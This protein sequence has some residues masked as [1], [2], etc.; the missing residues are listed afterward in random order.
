M[1]CKYL[2][3]I[4]GLFAIASV[5]FCQAQESP[6]VLVIIADDLGV[7]F[8]DGFGVDGNNT[9]TPVIDSLRNNGITFL[10]TWATPQCTPT[11]AAIMSGKY[12]VK[13]GV[14]QVPGNL[15]LE[16][17]SIFSNLNENAP[18]D[19]TTAVIGKWHISN[20]VDVTHPFQHG[21]S[22]YEG[23]INGTIDDYYLWPKTENGEI[24]DVDEYVTTHFTNSA[25]DWISQQNQ[26]WLMFLSH[27]APHSPFQVPP[28][29]LYSVGS[30]DTDRR[31][32]RA[33]IEAMDHE[34][35][36]LIQSMSE[37]TRNNTVI[38][39]I[40]D[41]GTPGAVGQYYPTG[42]FKG[43]LYEGGIRVPMVISGAGVTRIGE[44]E[45]GLTQAA[46]IH[47]TILELAQIDL[48][49]GIHN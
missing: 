36:R 25:I 27:I 49:G 11:R 31:R 44:V 19:Y 13:T 6:N 20:P 15:D 3:L 26:P 8:L 23:V 48:N 12:G 17:Q 24:N 33:T 43:S 32:Y 34:I 30:P 10:N 22:H 45:S 47:A 41:N 39:F 37:E 42:H 29:G 18:D 14:T 5:N 28:D 2:S 21:L 1:N 46:D 9:E 4:G 38:I 35:G 16:H 7:D 40:G